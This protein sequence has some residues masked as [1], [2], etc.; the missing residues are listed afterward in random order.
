[1]IYLTLDLHRDYYYLQ[2]QNPRPPTPTR[3]PPTPANPTATQAKL[4][5]QFPVRI[6][7]LLE[8]TPEIQKLEAEMKRIEQ[9]IKEQKPKFQWYYD[10]QSWVYT[11]EPPEIKPP[12]EESKDEVDERDSED[13]ACSRDADMRP[14]THC[15]RRRAR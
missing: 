4:A 13:D 3:Q 10:G 1:M 11:T 14:R 8:P 12:S 15:R 7:K 5:E 6:N 2:I 9:E